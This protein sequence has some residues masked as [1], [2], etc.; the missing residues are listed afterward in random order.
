MNIYI[1]ESISYKM[2]IWW[3]NTVI[4]NIYIENNLTYKIAIWWKVMTSNRNK[5]NA[6]SIDVIINIMTTANITSDIN[7]RSSQDKFCK[8]LKMQDI[9][10]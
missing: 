10:G 6:N 8:W 2:A 9:S 7:I 5:R 1:A 4:A 3:K